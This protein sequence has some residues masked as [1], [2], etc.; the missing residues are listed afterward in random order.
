MPATFGERVER[1]RMCGSAPK[2]TL[3]HNAG[4]TTTEGG[5]D[6]A[7]KARA[8][9]KPRLRDLRVRKGDLA[10]GGNLGTPATDLASVLASGAFRDHVA[11][12]SP[13]Q[14]GLFEHRCALIRAM[15]RGMV[16]SAAAV[17]LPSTRPAAARRPSRATK[18]V[19]P[20]A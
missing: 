9:R 7:K 10:G 16:A 5:F 18:E 12:R 14:S 11:A 15:T 8:A 20:T 3:L 4:L 17:D 13:G 6:M 2:A 19:C 1:V